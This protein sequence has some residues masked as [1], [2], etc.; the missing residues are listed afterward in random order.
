MGVDAFLERVPKSGGQAFIGAL[1]VAQGSEDDGWFLADGGEMSVEG[2]SELG[3][4]IL[5]PKPPQFTQILNIS[6]SNNGRWVH[7]SDESP[8]LVASQAYGRVRN[9][10]G[11][12]ISFTGDSWSATG[13]GYGVMGGQAYI[14]KSHGETYRVYRAP[15]NPSATSLS[16]STFG[17]TRSKGYRDLVTDANGNLYGY[18]QSNQVE[19]IT[20]SGSTTVSSITG[21]TRLQ[22]HKGIVYAFN[23]NGLY[24]I[25]NG[26][27]TRIRSGVA[28]SVF[29]D[30][31]GRDCFFIL[32]TSTFKVSKYQINGSSTSLLETFIVDNPE[33]S[34]N[35]YLYGMCQNGVELLVS[36]RYSNP[37]RFLYKGGGHADAAE[38]N[39]VS[40]FGCCAGKY[41]LFPDRY[42]KS[43]ANLC[44]VTLGGMLR[45]SLEIS[46]RTPR[47]Y[48][49]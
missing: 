49:K 30:A 5:M 13:V 11:S 39:Y 19:K 48:L 7:L 32:D 18:N 34:G 37:C 27:A 22:K 9:S 47:I 25:L 3:K 21:E 29:V 40:G 14:F 33:L 12:W 15:W 1:S 20:E 23:S 4:S 26:T 38:G 28:S 6:D 16:F 8:L 17:P 36:Y 42:N 41:Y 24:S 43:S 44:E 35:Y 46:G 45:P 10:S 2:L 31:E